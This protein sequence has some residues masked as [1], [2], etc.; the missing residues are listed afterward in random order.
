MSILNVKEDAAALQP[1]FE[2]AVASAVDDAAKTLVP[3]LRNALMS[4]LA[5]LTINVQITI[6]RKDDPSHA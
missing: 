4:A 5:G 3:A 6:S 2:A 1:V